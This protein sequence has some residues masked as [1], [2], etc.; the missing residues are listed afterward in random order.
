MPPQTNNQ[1]HPSSSG[2]KEI[3]YLGEE[4]LDLDSDRKGELNSVE[5]GQACVKESKGVYFYADL[6][7]IRYTTK[8][9]KK[10]FV[11]KIK[12]TVAP[13]DYK[14]KVRHLA[15][16][17][18]KTNNKKLSEGRFFMEFKKIFPDESMS[19]WRKLINENPHA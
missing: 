8:I 17:W 9:L 3:V 1:P 7:R 16:L 5:D 6:K 11:D 18:A 19:A 4:V 10:L 12:E 2:G 13:I 14:R 15:K